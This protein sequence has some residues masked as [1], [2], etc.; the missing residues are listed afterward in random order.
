MIE[1]ASSDDVILYSNFKLETITGCLEVGSGAVKSRSKV[2]WMIEM[3]VEW[4]C[5]YGKTGK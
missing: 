1:Q 2:A 3:I 4:K 5:C